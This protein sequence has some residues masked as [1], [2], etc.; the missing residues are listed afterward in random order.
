VLL[1]FC[2]YFY[3]YFS[4]RV[5]AVKA[6]SIFASIYN[7]NRC[8]QPLR[9]EWKGSF[10]HHYHNNN[11][12]QQMTHVHVVVVLLLLTDG[13][14]SATYR[15]VTRVYRKLYTTASCLLQRSA[16][17]FMR[18]SWHQHQQQQQQQQ[19]QC[20]IDRCNTYYRR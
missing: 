5:K 11:N 3:F 12:N 1:I 2:F 7:K 15:I 19:Q 4:V 8:R 13:K 9:I 16:A 6:Y 18:S 14:A 20:N 10:H 17:L